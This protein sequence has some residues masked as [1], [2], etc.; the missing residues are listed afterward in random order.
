MTKISYN[1]ID[2]TV[3]R[4]RETNKREREANKNMKQMVIKYEKKTEK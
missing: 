2:C 1:K 4:E 3:R